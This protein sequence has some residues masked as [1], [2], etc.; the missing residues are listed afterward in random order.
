MDMNMIKEAC[1]YLW[2]ELVFIFTTTIYLFFLNALNND[3]FKEY[4]EININ[5]L[6]Y[7][8]GI[9]IYYFVGA[10]I[11]CIAGVMLI[12][13]RIKMFK[14]SDYGRY[15]KN[16]LEDFIVDIVVII[17]LL[18]FIGLIIYFINNP[19]LRAMILLIGII[20]FSCYR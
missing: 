7:K 16:T 11:L 2:K 20:V 6:F 10:V 17:V 19:I 4:K 9:P 13:E 18:V 8:N 12:H 1:I 3:L 5:L 14:F 15:I